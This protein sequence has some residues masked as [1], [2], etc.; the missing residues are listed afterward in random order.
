MGHLN[1]DILKKKK[2]MFMCVAHGTGP[3][4]QEIGVVFTGREDVPQGFH[5]VFFYLFYF[6]CKLC[7]TD[8]AVTLPLGRFANSSSSEL[9]SFRLLYVDVTLCKISTFSRIKNTSNFTDRGTLRK[10]MP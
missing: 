7:V 3:P 5:Q 6:Y 4:V 9:F 10:K 8:T 2:R 1:I